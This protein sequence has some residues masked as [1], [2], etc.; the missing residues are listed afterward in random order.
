MSI[1]K[2]I[3]TGLLGGIL[4][5]LLLSF[6]AAWSI[7]QVVD[8]PNNIKTALRQSGVYS[9]GVAD[10]LMQQQ[11]KH[12]DS[13]LPIS[14]NAVQTMVKE[15]FS[16]QYLQTQ[17]EHVI[18]S[19]YA[20]LQ[21]KQPTLAFDVDLTPAK[22][23]LGD[24][25]QT[26]VAERLNELP[27]CSANAI[28]NGTLDPFN[29]TC[30][31]AGVDKASIASQARQNAIGNDFFKNNHLTADTIKTNNGDTIDQR[32]A[33]APRT[34]RHIKVWLAMEAGLIALITLV[35]ILLAPRKR[36]GLKQ[37][38]YAYLSIGLIGLVAA[39]IISYL[40]GAAAKGITKHNGGVELQARFV[41]ATQYMV[42]DLHM[43]WW[44]YSFGLIALGLAGLLVLWFTRRAAQNEAVRLAAAPALAPATAPVAAPKASRAVPRKGGAAKKVVR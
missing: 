20:W 5:T 44:A 30:V 29:A 10:A 32:L 39:S 6:G 7:R 17:A 23:A 27:A 18:D 12:S 42:N 8:N 11:T 31:P 43:Y 9:D 19:I 26:Y 21:G 16:P 40:I 22:N 15:S 38:S 13:S 36:S 33:S 25:V 3:L 35:I 41:K 14:N 34:Y 24:R 4:L 1:L 37:V 28:P 2:R